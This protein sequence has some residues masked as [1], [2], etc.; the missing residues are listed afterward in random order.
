MQRRTIAVAC[1]VRHTAPAQ[2]ASSSSAA[3]TALSGHF[4]AYFRN[5]VCWNHGVCSRNV[6]RAVDATK[7]ATPSV[8]AVTTPN[9]VG[10]RCVL[11]RRSPLPPP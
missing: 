3:A 11:T 9:V 5:V 7:S 1:A 6:R 10:R 4:A 2:T 8:T